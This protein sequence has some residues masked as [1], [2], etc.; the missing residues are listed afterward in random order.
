MNAWKW[1]VLEAAKNTLI[2]RENLNI[3]IS[4]RG[5]I[6]R[7][8]SISRIIGIMHIS[9]NKILSWKFYTTKYRYILRINCI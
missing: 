3:D 6:N 1:L 8:F 4:H 9:T 2:W 5:K 7:I